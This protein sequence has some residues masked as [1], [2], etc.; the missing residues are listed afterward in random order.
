MEV[1][2]TQNLNISMWHNDTFGR[3]SFLGEVDLD[4]SEWDF[5]NTQINEYALKA[6]VKAYLCP[7]CVY[8]GSDLMRHLLTSAQSF[9]SQHKLQHR[10]PHIWW[11]AEDRWESPWDSCRRCLTVSWWLLSLNQF[12]PFSFTVSLIVVWPRPQVREHLGWRL[13]RCRFG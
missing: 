10:L 9:R 11:T 7:V 12:C 4:L 2:K 6:R 5:S 3:N 8:G 1:L 13:V